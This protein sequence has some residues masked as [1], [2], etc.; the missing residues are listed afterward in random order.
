MAD[1]EPGALPPEDRRL[2]PLTGWTRAHWESIADLL[3]DGLRPHASP[4]HALI[5]V[6]DARGRVQRQRTDGLEA[7]ARSFLLA[8]ARLAGSNGAAPG[9]LAAR[10]ARGLTAGA[11]PASGESWPPI[12]DVS[13]P[14]VEAAQIA[15]GLALSRP[16]IWDRLAAGDQARL[17]TWLA[18]VHGKRFWYNN[19]ILFQ[20]IVNAF[21]KSAGFPHRQ[22]EIDGNLDTVD[23]WYRRDGWYTDGPGAN[24]DY[25]VGWAIH[26]YTLLWC[27]IDG[28]VSDAPRAA[29]YR[30]RA[31]RYLEQ[32]RFLFGANGAPL[33]HGRSLTYRFAAVAPLWAG[34][35][36]D[37]TSLAPGEIRRIASGVLRHF[38]ERGAIRDGLLTRGWY[39]EFPAML[40]YYSGHGSPYWA[41]SGFLGLVLPSA[42]PVWTETEE[43][44]AIER[45]D[46]CV[47]LAEPGF[48][49]RGTRADG[50][51]RVASHRSDHYPL[52]QPRGLKLGLKL[53]RAGARLVQAIKGGALPTRAGPD[54]AH[55]RKLAYSTHAAPEV[56]GAGDARD[57][58]SHI[59]LVRA[60]GLASRRVRIHPIAIGD[61]FAASAFYPEEPNW[62]ERIETVSVARGAAE[63]RVH[64]ITAKHPARVRD[65]GFAIAGDAPPEAATGP[66]WA[67]S[68]RGDGLTSFIAG[69]HGFD[70]SG[71]QRSQATNP[72]GP[73]SAT[74]YLTCERLPR[75]EAVFVSLVVLSGGRLTEGEALADIVRVDVSGRQVV[76][77]CRDGESFFVQ[78]VAA[79][80][81]DRMLGT[82]RLDGPVRFA[83]VSPDGTT[84]VYRS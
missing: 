56:G 9:D 72:F 64:H 1:R 57:I 54:D 22:D 6:P 76:V 42:H 74:P 38:V 60:S 2:S 23:S 83:R 59:A 31:S 68:A 14:M 20:V 11:D 49:V 66:Q 15:L 70:G 28:D 7:F 3:L 21:L 75:P 29:A 62:A 78:L 45:G 12:R 79:E 47:T 17:A 33:Y 24:Y 18:G 26:F 35:L 5:F 34:A 10:Y 4:T 39:H 44:M 77:S 81:V 84:F 30:E 8:A 40:Q 32:L 53:K 69:L 48:V 82:L 13:Q 73:H 63:M 67:L 43:P 25:Y 65:G 61:R 16:W 51:V 41:S 27:R 55:Y 50:I 37:A 52:S 58:D 46:F 19:W 36:L 80:R 71:V